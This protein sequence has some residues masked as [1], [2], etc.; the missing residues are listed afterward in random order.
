MPMFS[1]TPLVLSVAAHFAVAGLALH[2]LHAGAHD[3]ASTREPTAYEIQID[4]PLTE[5]PAEPAE[6]S[7]SA[8]ENQRD[9][10]MKSAVHIAAPQ[11]PAERETAAEPAPVEP[12]HVEALAPAP[13]FALTVPASSNASAITPAGDQT[14]TAGTA[15]TS[16]SN[17]GLGARAGSGPLAESAVDSPARLRVGTAPAYTAAALSAGIEADVPLEIV[18][19]EAGAV[20]SARSAAP[21]GYG[22]DAAAIQSVLAY[23]FAPALRAGK[24]VA[25]R[26][27]WLMRFQLR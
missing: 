5:A 15:P 21:V 19:S 6:A 13:R 4:E 18:V 3:R 14:G 27:R 17:A 20:T 1:S 12:E 26:M 25:V 10:P 9:L 24:A 8:P 22:L 7:A 16:G 2:H 11:A 23:R